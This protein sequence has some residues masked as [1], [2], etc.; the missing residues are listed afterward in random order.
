MRVLIVCLKKRDAKFGSSHDAGCPISY[1]QQQLS[2]SWALE[3]LGHSV[4]FKVYQPS[5]NAYRGLGRLG[6]LLRRFVQFCSR[7]KFERSLRRMML[8]HSVDL[9]ILP[10]NC[11]AFSS[12]F[13]RGLRE[14]VGCKFVVQHGLSPRWSPPFQMWGV[15]RESDL[16]VTNSR[17]NE[18]EF[19]S[20][21]IMQ[22]TTLP[23]AASCARIHGEVA[24]DINEPLCDVAFVGSLG[25]KLYGRRLELLRELIKHYDLGIWCPE[26][27]K[28]MED[29]GLAKAYRGN[30]SRSGCPD[31]YRR[32][33]ITLNIHGLHMPDGGN[34]STF[35]IPA[36]GGM[37]VVDACWPEWF[38]DGEEVVIARSIEEIK[39]KLDLL[40]SDAGMREAIA[41]RGTLRA[42]SE[43]TFE[44]RMVRLTELLAN[45]YE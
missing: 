35:E 19:H 24:R 28:T 8:N 5:Q 26:D 16:T 6:G 1:D 20:K 33:K 21:G 39:Q 18:N 13:I 40:L 31:I 36:S 3:N 4:D 38:E 41:L 10:G 22:A 2:W 29:W 27:L 37:Q 14:K 9:L 25:G 15:C 34:L 23:M 30:V 32:S 45:G 44:N 7:K 11:Y 17:G 42:R 43:H 12:Q